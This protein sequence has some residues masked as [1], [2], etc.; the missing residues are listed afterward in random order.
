[1]SGSHLQDILPG[2]RQALAR[3]PALD[4]LADEPFL[5]L[6]DTGLAHWHVRLGSS[7]R[8]ARIPKHSQMRLGPAENLAYQAACFDRAQVSG[9]TP[10]LQGSLQPAPDLPMGA[11]IVQWVGGRPAQ[12]PDDLDAVVEALAAIH[13]LPLPPAGARP[14]LSSPID[15][16]AA[17]L[18]EI[19]RQA[20][21]LDRAG[22]AEGAAAAIRQELAW[23]Q[24]LVQ[25][26]PRPPRSLI[27]FDAHPGNFLV[28]P[29]G[30][31]VLVDLEKARYAPPGFDLAH[32]TLYTSTTWDVS[33]RAVLSH[34][35]IARAIRSWSDWVDPLL[36]RGMRGWFL[37]LRRLMW[38]W[39]ITWCAK[40]R[41]L[42]DKPPRQLANTQGSAEDWSAA[43]SEQALIAH[44][45]DRVDHY[46]DGGTIAL[47]RREWLDRDGPLA[48]M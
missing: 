45:K 23:A 8:L 14:P 6:N 22:L 5:P 39:S 16:L 17:M 12:F 30:D 31:A 10:M 7:K 41:V 35:E 1:M 44:V 21:Y 42:S 2:L 3:H 38:L 43:R 24:E 25:A 4:A 13:N 28:S 32:A 29:R 46:L 34:E 20:D 15:P 9:H 19:R 33:S 48:G 47:V 40:W 27:A 36:A 26:T 11:L 37:P 18:T